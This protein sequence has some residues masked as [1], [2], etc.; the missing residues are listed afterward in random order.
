MLWFGWIF[1][2]FFS[3]QFSAP[4]L[5]GTKRQTYASAEAIIMMI[6]KGIRRIIAGITWSRTNHGHQ[7]H[8]NIV[9]FHRTNTEFIESTTT[10]KITHKDVCGVENRTSW[11]SL[12]L[13]FFFGHANSNWNS[14]FPFVIQ[15]PGEKVY[16]LFAP[17]GAA[18]R[19]QKSTMI[20]SSGQAFKRKITLCIR[21]AQFFELLFYI[22]CECYT[23]QIHT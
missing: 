21:F 11:K 22:T 2:G 6:M 7:L 12:H 5:A 14:V 20:I 13:T 15:P 4:Y 9:S 18:N 1:V 8:A 19:N 17:M 10:R 23:M 3:L 16:F